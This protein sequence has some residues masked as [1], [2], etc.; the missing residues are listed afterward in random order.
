MA[1]YRIQKNCLEEDEVDGG[2]HDTGNDD[3]YLATAVV[4][5]EEIWVDRM[6]EE[7]EAQNHDLLGPIQMNCGYLVLVQV[8]GDGIGSCLDISD[9]L[10]LDEGQLA[11]SAHVCDLREF[12]GKG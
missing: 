12:P 1:F 3:D 7:V 11:L 9:Y 8:Q 5:T 4:R 10:A 2:G 6:D